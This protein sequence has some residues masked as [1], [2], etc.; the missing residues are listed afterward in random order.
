[1][2]LHH[3][4]D[5]KVILTSTML[6]LTSQLLSSP[7]PLKERKGRIQKFLLKGKHLQK[8]YARTPLQVVVSDYAKEEAAVALSP[9]DSESNCYCNIRGR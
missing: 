5:A 3:L 2:H 1:M 4:H 8:L 9:I 7:S 6:T